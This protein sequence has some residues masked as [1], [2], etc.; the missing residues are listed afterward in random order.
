MRLAILG[1]ILGCV[2]IARKSPL[3][4]SPTSTTAVSAGLA[5]RGSAM[6]KSL[7]LMSK[8]LDAIRTTKKWQRLSAPRSYCQMLVTDG[9]RRQRLELAM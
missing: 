2:W 6:N 5:K 9:I 4:L 8:S 7:A 1:I 3:D